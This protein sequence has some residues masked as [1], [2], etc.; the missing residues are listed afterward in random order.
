MPSVRHR[1]LK[2]DGF[3]VFYREAGPPDAPAVLLPHGYPC[4]SYEFRNLMPRLADR[5]RCVAPDFPG[6]GYSDTPKD[7]SYD[8]DGYAGFLDRFAH[9]VGLDRFAIYL[10]D[11]GSQIG[12]R[13]AI[14]RPERITAL[15][16]QNGDIYEDE[17]G[18]KYAP[19][20]A[21][22]QNPTPE[23]RSKLGEAVDEEGFRDEFL[24]DLRPELAEQIPPD[25]WKLHWSLM[26][27]RRREIAVDV[28][29]GLKENLAWFPRYQAYLRDQRPPTLIVWGPQDG[30]MPAGS[31]RAYLRDLPDA[32]LHLLD[33][34]HWLLETN[35]DEV[36]ELTR[37]FLS[38][39]HN[40]NEGSPG[41]M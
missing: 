24:N 19:L 8:F 23:G 30:Y 33:G 40:A 41:K 10:H 14:R 4:S 20:Q 12:L 38:R 37:D 27:P 5:W 18:P 15:I 3:D 31:A 26:T 25:L 9:S 39:V 16:I 32:E 35:L 6:C 17:L 13:L 36:A 7:F 34:G 28:I 2:L 11:F 1:R 29:A 21:H 22:F